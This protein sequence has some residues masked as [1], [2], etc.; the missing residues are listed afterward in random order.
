MPLSWLLL[1]VACSLLSILG[2]VL[3]VGELCAINQEI[4]ELNVAEFPLGLPRW[5]NAEESICKSGDVGSILGQK[6][7]LEEGMAMHSSI[8]AWRIPWT[9]ESGGLQSIGLQSGQDWSDSACMHTRVSFNSNSRILNWPHF[10]I[11]R[12]TC[13][14]FCVLEA[15]LFLIHTMG[16]QELA[17]W[18]W[19]IHGHRLEDSFPECLTWDLWSSP[20][21]SC[22]LCPVFPCTG[23]FQ[24]HNLPL[25]SF[26]SFL[27][28]FSN[29]KTMCKMILSFLV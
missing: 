24:A 9:E 17:T 6:D 20:K 5:P 22:L 26:F 8:L 12:Q 25:A 11:W 18:W 29:W 3:C 7:P 14:H 28:S 1:G 27:T 19:L 15:P 10:C 4:P 2:P 23:T 21:C 16:C 13:S